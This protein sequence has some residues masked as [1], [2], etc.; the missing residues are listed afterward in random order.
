MT[1]SEHEDALLALLR[2][3]FPTA[4]QV[5]SMPRGI[6]DREAKTVRDGAVWVMYA[7]G[8]PAQGEPP[9]SGSHQ[10]FWT[11]SV[12]CLAKRYRSDQAGAIAAL[13]LLETVIDTLDGATIEGRDV[14]RI[15]DAQMAIPEEW[16]LMGY[17]AQFTIE[18]FTDRRTS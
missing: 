13:E 15:A 18:V 4:I 17:E 12:I 3:E 14:S 7:G 8:A 11:W 6:A 10:E 1:R 5:R 9:S 16:N 2:A